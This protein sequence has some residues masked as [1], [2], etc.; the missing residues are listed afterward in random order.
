[1]AR[2]NLFPKRKNH[3]CKLKVTVVR[4]NMP[5][6]HKING[7]TLPLQADSKRTLEANLV[8]NK[9]CELLVI[10]MSTVN[11]IFNRGVT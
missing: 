5:K 2:A 4:S 7:S 11:V 8:V 3:T 9:I 10:T 6:S 1:M